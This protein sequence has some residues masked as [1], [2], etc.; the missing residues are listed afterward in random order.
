MDL[1]LYIHIPFCARKCNYCDFLSF[2]MSEKAHEAYISQ[3]CCELKRTAPAAKDCDV[4]SVFIGGG[5]P[6]LL[7]PKYIA[8]IMS[9]VRRHYHV[10]ADAEITIECNPASTLR[11]KF[12]VYRESGINRL[13]IGLQSADNEEL[14]TLGR[15]HTFEEFLKCF[16]GARQEGFS[17]IN[18][19]LMN[20]IP[21]QTAASWKNTLKKVTMLK[22]EHLSIYNLIVEEGTPFQRL[23]DAGKL[24]LPAEDVQTEIDALT[25]E[26][27]EKHGYERYEVSNYAKA[28]YECRH[29]LGYWSNVPYLGFGLG[30]ASYIHNTRYSNVRNF[31]DYLSL[32]MDEE[33]ANGFAKLHQDVQV[34]SRT[35][36]MEEFMFIG[37]RRVIG[38]SEMDF[39]A[40]FSVS[41]ESVFGE[42]LEQ[43]VRQGFMKHEHYRYAFTERGMDVSNVLLSQFLLG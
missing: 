25:K 33:A 35:E 26:F 38:V 20:D 42:K 8:R 15:L 30:A 37:L 16:Q 32:D 40:R 36:Q 23:Q 17:N 41:I 2:S 12:A 1:A 3:L 19:D 29:N 10:L 27:T 11:Y 7:D 6:S 18:I 31:L 28:G 5:T 39:T 24:E 21:E 34:L 4:C 13:S 22:P 9:V 14:R 43:F